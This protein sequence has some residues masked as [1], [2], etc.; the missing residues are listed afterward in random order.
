MPLGEIGISGLNRLCAQ[1]S[2]FCI[3]E[4]TRTGLA[5]T[6]T[7]EYRRRFHKTWAF[8]SSSHFLM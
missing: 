6:G 7:I 4:L 5:G 2:S 3:L 1:C 8:A